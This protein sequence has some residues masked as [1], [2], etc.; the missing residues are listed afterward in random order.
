MLEEKLLQASKMEAIGR[1]AGGVAH[2]FNNVLTAISGY[3][4]FA[5]DSV[6]P[7]HEIAADLA[8][9]RR[10]ADRAS[11]LTRQLLA[12]G[13]KQVMASRVLDL[14]SVVSD[15]ES[16]LRR[17]IGEDIAIV[18]EL[19]EPLGRVMADPVQVEQ[20]LM[21]LA[22][23]ARDAMPG[24][25]RITISTE[26][27]VLEDETMLALADIE[28]G[29]YIRLSVADTG[30]GMDAE[31]AEHVFEPFFTTKAVGEGTGL[32]LATVYGIVKQ[33]G[34]HVECE[35][36]VGVGTSIHVYLPCH[37]ASEPVTAPPGP[38]ADPAPSPGPTGTETILL[39]EDDETV[40][41]FVSMALRRRGYGVLVAD[42]AA[43]AL[44]LAAEHA[45]TISLLV[46]DVVMPQMGGRELAQR[47]SITHPSLPVLFMSG[48]AEDL[49]ETEHL[50]GPGVPLLRKPFT[51]DFLARRVRELLDESA[52]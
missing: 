49:I 45:D 19:Q 9:V 24:G 17:M 16:M 37:G 52:R 44:E 40:R 36:E 34:G 22:V 29:C 21:N 7:D 15:V 1:L 38:A 31:T 13:R 33:S 32:G 42:D 18:T 26:K 39:V 10:A 47:L 28:P 48:Y 50:L 4:E 14:N 25:G 3:V 27:V 51:L 11:S 20:I 35:S 8:Q 30:V 5:I 41:D 6:G 12:F 46:T 23:N 2:D 43:H